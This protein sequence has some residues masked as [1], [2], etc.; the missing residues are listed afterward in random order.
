[1][2]AVNSVTGNAAA[3]PAGPKKVG[4]DYDS[5]LKLLVAELKNQ[6]PTEPMDATQYV[7]QLATFSNVEQ[8]IKTNDK[9]DEILRAGFLQQ[10]GSLIGRTLTSP[11]G[12]ITGK[13]EE[14]RVFD[15]GIAAILDNGEQ[16]VV[17]GGVTI[18]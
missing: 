14:V 3:A 5:F 15:D 16:V 1:M 11:D 2:D 7:S 17:G 4:V 13:I 12:A 8:S 18:S 10:A 6:D 9:L